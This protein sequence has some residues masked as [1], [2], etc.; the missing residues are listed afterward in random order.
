MS[1]D[2]M[3]FSP[4][5]APRE[6]QAFAQWYAAQT[7]WPEHHDYED[8][9]VTSPSLKAWFLDMI[10]PYPAL[11]GPFAEDE[12]P[13]DESV[14]T[15]YSIGRHLVYAAFA[16]SQAAH[17]RE[18]AFELAALHC[19]GFFDLSAQPATVWLPDGTNGLALAFQC[20]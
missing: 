11:N 16:S 12:P 19:V 7:E 18:R 10:G 8:P 17:A 13:D 4:A 15:D 6:P 9:A 5:A 20:G 1:Y 14:L 3:V 2:L